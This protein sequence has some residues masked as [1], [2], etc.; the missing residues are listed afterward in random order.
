MTDQTEDKRIALSELPVAWESEKAIGIDYRAA[1][2]MFNEQ[3]EM[4]RRPR[5]SQAGAGLPAPAPWIRRA[6]SPSG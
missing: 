5:A 3:V 4:G 6:A 1:P 2:S